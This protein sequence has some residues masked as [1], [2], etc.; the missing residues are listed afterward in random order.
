MASINR[1]EDFT[2]PEWFVEAALYKCVAFTYAFQSHDRVEFA[3]T[4]TCSELLLS[5]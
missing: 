1:L 5:A 4:A 2:F 3:V